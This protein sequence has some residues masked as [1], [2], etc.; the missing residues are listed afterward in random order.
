[1]GRDKK[2]ECESTKKSYTIRLPLVAEKVLFKHYA[3]G[4]KGIIDLGSSSKDEGISTIV[5]ED[6]EMP[7][8]SSSK[9]AYYFL[10]QHKIRIKYWLPMCD[11][12]STK[13][14]PNVTNKCCWWDRHKFSSPP[15]GC[16]LKRMVNKTGERTHT[17]FLT[18]GIFCSFPCVQAYILEQTSVLYKES[19]CLLS[20]MRK[21]NLNSRS[22]ENN[23]EIRKVS[24]INI[25]P[26][27]SWK[28]LKDYGGHLN[29]DEFRASFGRTAYNETINFHRPVK[30][31]SS[32]NFIEEIKIT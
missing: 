18:E 32:A 19:S 16:P 22:G 4:K 21:E 27:P 11:M 15:I 28:L 10:D 8:E 31:I 1:M 6:D 26:A 24:L 2:K 12:K 13:Q 14:L 5:N 23:V 9:G 29:I 17:Y 30:C 25:E 3:K 7:V 20:L